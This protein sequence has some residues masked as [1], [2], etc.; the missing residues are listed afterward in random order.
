MLFN[1]FRVKH[2]KHLPVAAY[3]TSMPLITAEIGAAAAATGEG[4]RGEGEERYGACGGS[5]GRGKGGVVLFDSD[6]FCF[7]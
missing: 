3:A 6:L 7:V 1:Y 4:G 2:I 5:D